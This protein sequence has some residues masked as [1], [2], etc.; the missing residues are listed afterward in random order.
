[1]RTKKYLTLLDPLQEKFGDVM[2]GFLLLA[3]LFAE[4]L[5][6]ASILVALGIVQCYIFTHYRIPVC[7][8]GLNTMIS[9]N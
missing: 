4:I 2:T 1:M 3:A 9:P 5:W 6:G 8:N 7:P